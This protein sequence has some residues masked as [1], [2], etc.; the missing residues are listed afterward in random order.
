MDRINEI[1]KTKKFLYWSI[2]IVTA[3]IF[4]GFFWLIYHKDQPK[5]IPPETR[6]EIREGIKEEI[7][8]P[9]QSVWTKGG[10]AL[11]DAAFDAGSD[12]PQFGMKDVSP[13]GTENWKTY[14]D[15]DWG[16]LFKYPEDY[17]I[18]KTDIISI[19]PIGKSDVGIWITSGPT[20]KNKEE[21]WMEESKKYDARFEISSWQAFSGREAIKA[22]T[23]AGLGETHYIFVAREKY[24]DILTIGPEA[25]EKIVSTFEFI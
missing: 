9:I 11:A 8:K 14:Y 25:L 12:E 18:D 6:G 5:I 24:F 10:N 3:F 22:S 15:E 17:H 1:I 16:I 23:A 21:W 7:V 13:L 2:F 4:V 19:N 20:N